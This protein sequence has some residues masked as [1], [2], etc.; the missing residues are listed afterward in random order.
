MSAKC[1]PETTAVGFQG[2]QQPGACPMNHSLKRVCSKAGLSLLNQRTRS[3]LSQS[4]C[5]PKSSRV[6]LGSSIARGQPL[7]SCLT[8]LNLACK[9]LLSLPSTVYAR[10]LR[11][12]VA[13][14][15]I[16]SWHLAH[17]SLVFLAACLR[18]CSG[19]DSSLCLS[20]NAVKCRSYLRTTFSA[21]PSTA[22]LV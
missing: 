16:A 21:R 14:L 15:G 12:L 2:F 10:H 8:R 3:S 13:N 11:I 20:F 5:Q 7:L 22:E 4:P 1:R 9:M 18:T 17:F 19:S 6:I